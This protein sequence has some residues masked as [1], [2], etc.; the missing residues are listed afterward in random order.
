MN[1]LALA[2]TLL[3]L[4]ACGEFKEQKQELTTDL[5]DM[6]LAD[7]TSYL[8]S[9]MRVS[10]DEL[11]M[12]EIPDDR[13]DMDAITEV[14]DELDPSHLESWEKWTCRFTTNDIFM[15][16]GIPA[17]TTAPAQVGSP[18]W[19]AGQDL[20]MRETMVA[21]SDEVRD[22]NAAAAKNYYAAGKM[23]DAAC[24]LD[25]SE[26]RDAAIPPALTLRDASLA[27]L[28]LVQSTPWRCINDGK[29]SRTPMGADD[30]T[31]VEQ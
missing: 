5:A 3:A 13:V 11:G 24:D 30:L 4:T 20:Y 19:W 27:S 9:K 23:L 29:G 2:S 26:A 1:R 12:V 16:E 8:G 10:C 18:Q 17:H 22:S 25:T 31:A 15:T 6:T 28:G 14:R 21:D 7:A